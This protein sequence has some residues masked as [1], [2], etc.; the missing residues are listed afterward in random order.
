MYVSETMSVITHVWECIYELLGTSML[1]CESVVVCVYVSIPIDVV[2]VCVCVCTVCVCA[3]C[4]CM[5][6]F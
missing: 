3:C 5:L 4:M 2:C 1:V 6:T